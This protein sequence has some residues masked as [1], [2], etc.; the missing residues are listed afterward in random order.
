METHSERY[1]LLPVHSIF[2]VLFIAGKFE[3]VS[4]FVFGRPGSFLK[5]SKFPSSRLT[6]A[7]GMF[8]TQRLSENKVQR[9]PGLAVHSPKGRQC[10]T[11]FNEWEQWGKIPVNSW[12]F[13]WN[14]VRILALIS[15]SVLRGR[16]QTQRVSLW[17]WGFCWF[18]LVLVLLVISHSWDSWINTE[19]MDFDLTRDY[20][21]FISHLIPGPSR[22]KVNVMYK[23]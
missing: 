1:F 2:K 18:P 10:K 21:L 14:N 11:N 12:N 20:V 16:S 23:W 6:V 7:R 5:L 19:E 3:Q 9:T 15:L 4:L 13:T 8:S 17:I 22:F